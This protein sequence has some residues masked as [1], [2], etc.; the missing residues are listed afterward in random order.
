MKARIK[1]L[2]G[3]VVACLERHKLIFQMVLMLT[4]LILPYVSYKVFFGR[5]L[6]DH[7]NPISWLWAGWYSAVLMIYFW[8][9]WN[10]L[11]QIVMALLIF[12]NIVILSEWLLV[13][14][15]GGLLGPIFVLFVMIVPIIPLAALVTAIFG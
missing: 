10:L 8:K 13:S 1:A 15:M 5:A 3:R 2:F 9:W 12:A 14:L 4:A 11:S 6:A 7:Y